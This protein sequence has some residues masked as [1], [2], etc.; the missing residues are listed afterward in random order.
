MS[1]LGYLSRRLLML[2]LTVSAGIFYLVYI[3]YQW[4]LDDSTEFYLEQDMLWAK[5]IIATEQSLPKNTEFKQFYL[6]DSSLPKQYKNLIL[7]STHAQSFFLQDQ[8]YYHYGLHQTF[9]DNTSVTVIHKFLV[10]SEVEGMSL[11][12]VSIAASFLLI[13]MM[14]LG[15]WLIYQR[16][17]YSMQFLLTA[18]AGESSEN[19]TNLVALPKPD[20]IEIENIV[21]ALQKAL[22]SLE[23]N[24]QQ[25]RLFI[26]TLSHELRT[27]M[28]TI[29]VALELLAKKELNE[30]VREKLAIIFNSNQQMQHLSHQLL[31]LW[32]DIKVENETEIDILQQLK[33]TI[34][35]LDQAFDCQQRFIIQ[36][37]E[38]SAE[39]L[40]VLA[41]QAHVKLLL[42]NVC[43]NAI[44][45]S[46]GPIQIELSSNQLTISN[47]KARNIESE[48]ES[49]AE[50]T[51]DPLVAGSGIGLIIATRAAEQLGWELTNQET[52]TEYQIR[53]EFK[54]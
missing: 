45:H 3:L 33:E 22:S 31:T 2:S 37:L 41:S 9:N 54:R 16:I 43:K 19:S 36:A 51:V 24:N 47:G 35:E 29:Q 27:P 5:E 20:F 6:S 23:N 39:K 53:I 7:P 13:I 32:T 26:Q 40:I 17:A 34:A 15:A 14:L 46:D 10:D 12:E 50:R 44:V 25:E 8:H 42:N 1:L 18:V 52:P 30:N 48:V 28:A 38:N 4:G 21:N 11:F 49:E